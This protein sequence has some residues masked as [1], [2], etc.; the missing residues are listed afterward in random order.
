MSSR[1]EVPERVNRLRREFQRYAGTFDEHPPFSTEQLEIHQAVISKRCALGSATCAIMDDKFLEDLREL[2]VKWG[3]DSR[4]A[5][6]VN[7][8]SFKTNIRRLASDICSLEAFTI[9]DPKEKFLKV[10]PTVVDIIQKLEI[11]ENYARVVVG[12]K[13]LHHLLPDLIPPMDR[14][15]TGRFFAWHRP[16]FQNR[17]PQILKEGLSVFNSV[18]REVQPQLLVG[19]GWRTSSTKILDN[20]IVGY[21]IVENLPYSSCTKIDHSAQKLPRL[22]KNYFFKTFR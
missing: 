22:H 6:L 16:Y 1:S 11:N 7:I 9:L 3:M 17:Q 2:L 8:E 5:K 19:P 18:A 13:A 20:A 4:M 14:K 12:T 21:C 10:I 15:Y